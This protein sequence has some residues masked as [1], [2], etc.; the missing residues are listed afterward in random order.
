MT[1]SKEMVAEKQNLIKLGFDVV[2]PEFT[3]EYSKLATKDEMHAESYENKIKFDLIRSYYQTINDGDAI[4]VINSEKKGIIGYIGGNTLIEMA[5]A[6]ILNKPIYLM[7]EVPKM[8]YSDEI[9]AMKP[10]VLNGNLGLI[11][12]K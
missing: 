12:V 3:E 11:V 10:V 2:L 5:F 4:L 8:T 1:A 9:I 7:N 6:H